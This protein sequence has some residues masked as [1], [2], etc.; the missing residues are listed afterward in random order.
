MTFRSENSESSLTAKFY[1]HRFV[2]AWILVSLAVCTYMWQWRAMPLFSDEVAFM[3]RNARF[4]ADGGELHGRFAICQSSTSSIPLIFYP[5]AIFVTE[6]NS[7][8]DWALVRI[9]P[10]ISLVALL[11][12]VFAFSWKSGK[13][14]GAALLLTAGFIG[15]AGSGFALSRPEIYLVFN[16]AT[17]L[18]IYSYCDKRS[19]TKSTAILLLVLLAAVSNVSIFVH[20]QGLI[21]APIALMLMYRISQSF[22]KLTARLIFISS[23]VYLALSVWYWFK[24]TQFFRCT[25]SPAITDF[26][27]S[28]T[29]PGWVKTE[30]SGVSSRLKG[31]F[32]VRFGY[33]DKFEFAPNSQVDY[34]PPLSPQE[35][36]SDVLMYPLNI[37]IT[38]LTGVI[39]LAF[40]LLSAYLL[41]R[42]CIK[43]YGLRQEPFPWLTK[44]VPF[45]TS[46]EVMFCTICWAHLG[47]LFVVTQINFYRA[48]YVN[49]AMVVLMVI[50]LH[51]VK[52]QTIK[53]LALIIG[54]ISLSLC[55]LSTVKARDHIYPRL[56]AGY[57][58]PS[59]PLASNWPKIEQDVNALKNMC[60]VSDDDTRIIVDDMTYDA[61]K[62]HKRVLPI[63]Y[64]ALSSE[65]IGVP[66]KN[67]I[68]D[69]KA[70]S[71]IARCGYFEGYD[72]PYKGRL[73]GLCC[74]TYKSGVAPE[75]LHAP[76]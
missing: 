69:V 55:A 74:S 62:Q 2:L 21:F 38:L 11:L 70:T 12:A 66:L 57:T 44:L 60:G 34:L 6:I 72:L 9:V 51:Q 40:M 22:D 17:C 4:F 18:F 43:L 36:N 31:E 26:I 37:A 53:R 52:N 47:L 10:I 42:V 61:L 71:A 45:A 35:L 63:T 15:V 5:A 13:S 16:G 7:V 25:E 1:R 20:P 32:F 30:A 23:T 50:A 19:L 68:K 54:M 56:A 3:V 46:N 59:I 48:F 33:F 27:H 29:L 24:L 8:S 58:G 64:M 41:V 28:M 76:D 75:V 65:I 49:L 73:N 14:I 67:I 39:L